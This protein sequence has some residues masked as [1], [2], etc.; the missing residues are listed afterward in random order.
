M[1]IE[2]KILYNEDKSCLVF[3]LKTTKKRVSCVHRFKIEKLF[4]K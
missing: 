2:I 3:T 1:P 4:V